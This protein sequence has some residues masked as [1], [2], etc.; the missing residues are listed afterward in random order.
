MCEAVARAPAA[1]RPL[2]TATIGLLTREPPRDAGELSRVAERLEVQQRDVGAASCSQ[3]CRK[4]LP[5]RSALLPT[6]TNDDSPTPSR[7]GGLDD[8]DPETAALREECR[9]RRRP[10]DGAANVALSRTSR[11]GVEHAEAIGSN[12]PH[13]GVTADRHQLL[14]AIGVLR[15]RAPQTRPRSRPRAQTPAAAHPRDHVEDPTGA[16]RPRPPGPPARGARS[17]SGKRRVD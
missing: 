8:R 16:G 12:Q 10:P 17:P 4:S 14:L 6:E 11:D 1:E 13:P 15:R 7:A 5:D 3:Y 2:L 9:R